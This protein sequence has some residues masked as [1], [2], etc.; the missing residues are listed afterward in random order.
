MTQAVRVYFRPQKQTEHLAAPLR[1]KH[2]KP[3]VISD[4]TISI[5]AY[6]KYQSTSYQRFWKK[7][8]NNKSAYSI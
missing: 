4:P 6:W 8:T 5:I 2:Q 3:K 7:E 1:K